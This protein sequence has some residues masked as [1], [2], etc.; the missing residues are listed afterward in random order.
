MLVV[1]FGLPG[2]AQAAP[3]SRSDADDVSNSPDIRAV[4]HNDTGTGS[5]AQ[6]EYYME[7]YDNF[8]DNQLLCGWDFDFNK[9]GRRDG[10]M[11]VSGEFRMTVTVFDSNGQ[12]A[13][14][15]TGSRTAVGSPHSSSTSTAA[16]TVRAVI[17]RSLLEKAGL[18]SN[19][20]DY[21][22][23]VQCGPEAGPRDNVPEN[24]MFPG[25]THTM[26]GSTA[27]KCPGHESDGRAQVVGTSGDDRLSA[28][29]SG[30]IVCGLE[31]NDVLRASPGGGTLLEGGDG[32]DVLC[33]RQSAPA[34]VIDGGAGIDRARFDDGEPVSNVERFAALGFCAG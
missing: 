15:G 12:S 29:S 20:N 26:S 1:A 22:Y 34:D 9:D 13:G 30:T 6:L 23:T 4:Y 14:D 32:I 11:Q 25:I 2:G 24:L 7:S 10:G 8:T 28:S 21:D 31:G 16:N 33:A 19:D 5:G 27:G 18:A 17:A 3:G